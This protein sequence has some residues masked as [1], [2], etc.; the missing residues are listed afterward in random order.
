MKKVEIAQKYLNS[1]YKGDIETATQMLDPSIKLTMEGNN[2]MSGVYSGIDA[3]FSAFGK[4]M[5]LTDNT[6]QMESQIEWLEGETRAVLFALESAIKDGKPY[7]FRRVIDY[8]IEN[9]KIVEITIYEGEPTIADI[10]F[11]A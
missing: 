5:D 8:Q 9:E 3:F 7:N 6:Y 1:V 11:A 4:M 2:Q 10:V